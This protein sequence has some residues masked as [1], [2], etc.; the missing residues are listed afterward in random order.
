MKAKRAYL[1]ACLQRLAQFQEV[2]LDGF[3]FKRMANGVVVTLPDSH[4]RIFCSP[5][6]VR[7]IH[8]SPKKAIK[9]LWQ[10]ILIREEY[11]RHDLFWEK[12]SN[13]R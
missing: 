4:L 1:N 8:L 5:N 11:I 9:K 6:V 7:S 10:L 12:M 3:T 13:V 2:E